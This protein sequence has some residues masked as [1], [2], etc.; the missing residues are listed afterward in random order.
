MQQDQPRKLTLGTDP[1]VS[2]VCDGMATFFQIDVTII[3]LLFA[4]S[5]LLSGMGLAVYIVCYLVMPQY[6]TEGEVR[7]KQLRRK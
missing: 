6:Q 5:L 3:R 4:L 1:I 2:G 7:R